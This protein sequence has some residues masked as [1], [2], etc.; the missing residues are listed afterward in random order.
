MLKDKD[1]RIA[2]IGLG[3]VG[4]PLAIELAKKFKV[5][6]FDIKKQRVR[7]LKLNFDQTLEVDKLKLKKTK[8]EFSYNEN[9]LRKAN[10]FIVTVPTGVDKNNIPDLKF[11]KKST[12]TISK[13]LKPKSLVIYESTV[14]PGCTEEFCL[15]ILKKN[16]KFKY[17]KDFFIGYSPERINPGDKK[18]NVTNIAKIV[19]G[20]SQEALEQIK[21]IYSKI[22]NSKIH[23]ASSIKIAEAAKII[24]NTQR[25]LNIGLMNELFVFF[26]KL[27]IPTNEVLK[28]AQTK[29]NFLKFFPGFVG[30][31]CI[32]VDPYYLTS[33]FRDLKLIPS[34]IQ[35]GRNTNEKFH[36][37]IAKKSIKI[38]KEKKFKKKILVLGYS[39][40]EN[41]PDY[42]N[43]RVYNL[44]KY[45]K[46]KQYMINIHDPY[47]SENIDN[48]PFKKFSTQNL[49]EINIK[50]DLIIL[51][52]PHNFYLKNF[53][54]IINLLSQKGL[55][56][57]FRCKLKSN[58]KVIQN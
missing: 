11:L 8:V 52:V 30:G 10:I 25:D 35:S 17:N 4:L 29:W 6:G 19:S 16:N 37:F 41:C 26:D 15:P 3:Y 1:I 31:H 28:A 34:V 40:K 39:F 48:F 50:Y 20:S 47:I 38:I 5:Y 42:R 21:N 49:E 32:S 7:N 45:L 55:I 23:V 12:Q 54:K 13:Y 18:K 57:D 9:I 2:V 46:K 36:E 27:G 33:K 56:Y 58:K 44:V 14:Y 22:V 53:N 51:A 24:E 43:S